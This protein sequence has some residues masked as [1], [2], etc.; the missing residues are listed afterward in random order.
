[1]KQEFVTLYGKA[2]VERDVLFIRN[3]DLPF[4]KT[5]LF[6]FFYEATFAGIFIL[7][8]F[9]T[10]GPHKYI[11]IL[12]WGFLLLSRLPQWYDLLFRRSYSNRI[13]LSRIRSVSIENDQYGLNSFVQLHLD[14][15]RYRKIPFRT[16]EKEYINFIEAITERITQP[17]LA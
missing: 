4:T 3:L 7:A 6:Q 8:F 1:M 17:Q 13:P 5:S 2:T 12:G 10:D 9:K 11:S 16:M 15:G 14:K